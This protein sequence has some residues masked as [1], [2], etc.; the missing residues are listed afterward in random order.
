[1]SHILAR[2]EGISRDLIG[3]SRLMRS[4]FAAFNFFRN[5]TASR[6]L[7]TF[8]TGSLSFVARKEDWV[9]VRE[10]FIENEYDM[11]DSLPGD[12]E[13]PFVLDLGANIGGFA[14]RAFR[15]WPRASV[16]S[17]EAA[18]DTF[19]ILEH[20]RRLNADLDW[21]AVQGAIWKSDG[22][23]VLERRNISIGHR[24][25]D[26]R[27]GERIRSLTLSSLLK[28]VEGQRIDLIKMDIEGAEA[29]VVPTIP[30]ILARTAILIIEVHTDRIDPADTYRTLAE[31]YS[32][33]WQLNDRASRKPVLMLSNTV[34]RVAGATPV[35]LDKLV[36]EGAMA[37]ARAAL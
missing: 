25:A 34:L 11:L 10:I 12:T 4:P 13:A 14:L 33:C 9:G 27:E 23:L 26:G 32:N 6:R 30:D 15:R 20:N 28:D 5:A 16:I 35:E 19:E 24:V 3:A 31:V 21:K 37:L 22:E 36:R 7:G 18:P 8:R 2:L 29:Q 1:M 17:V